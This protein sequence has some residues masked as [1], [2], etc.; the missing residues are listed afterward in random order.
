MAIPPV[1]AASST[2]STE[3]TVSNGGHQSIFTLS[4]IQAR[5]LDDNRLI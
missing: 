1:S 4:R 3:L 2:Q 5:V